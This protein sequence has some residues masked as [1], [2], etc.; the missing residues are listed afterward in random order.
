MIGGVDK[1]AYVESKRVTQIAHTLNERARMQFSTVPG[2]VPARFSE[3]LAYAQDGTTPLFGGVITGRG[4]A[5]FGVA[6]ANP[7]YTDIECGDYFTYFDWAYISLTYASPVT[8]EDVLTDLVAAL[9]A[10]YSI[11]L[12]AGQVTGPTLAPF[13]WD[14]KRASDA[15]R[16]LSDR[17]GYVASI[18]P[19]RELKMFVPGTDAAPFAMTD[20]DPHCRSFHWRDSDRIPANTVTGI[21]GPS[22]VGETAITHHWTGDGVATTF[23][24]VGENVRASSVWPGIVTIDGVPLPIWPPGEGGANDIEWDWQTN[25]GTLTFR[26]TSA[27]TY[28]TLGADIVLT[29]FP[30][31]PFA[32]TVTSGAT[33][34]IEYQYADPTITS[35]DQGAEDAQGKLDQL[36]QTPREI[37]VLSLDE[38]WE[39]GQA[40]TV[41]L[42]ERLTADFIITSDTITLSTDL[43][44]VYQFAATESELYQGSYL[45]QWRALTGGSSG[46]VTT[47]SGGGGSTT[48]TVLSSPVY[49]GGASTIAV[50]NPTTPKLIPNAVPYFATAS[51]TGRLRVRL[52]ARDAAVGIKATISD[53]STNTSTSIVT[54]QAFTDVSVIVAVASGSTYRV[55]LE[56]NAAGDGYIEYA[57]LEAA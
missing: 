47:V 17:T 41:D 38:G 2:Y 7:F 18:S 3:V 52:R 48:V 32:I 16:E 54:S 6:S 24:L 28:A 31:Y 25:D 23:A 21:F 49:M 40:L 56:N 30:L 50:T 44:W 39:S 33:P 29:Y 8:L 37:D 27:A 57:Q 12:D 4:S 14:R 19:I 43:F 20:G 5:D 42:T 51:F 34:V 22:G 13:T 26:G 36:D 11:A 35:Y 45:D 53:G 55:Y 10:S 15:V 9:P 46:G 1:T